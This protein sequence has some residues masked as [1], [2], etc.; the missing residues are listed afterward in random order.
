M[1]TY[2]GWVAGLPW[3]N[4][5]DT[6]RETLS[7][8]DLNRI[9]ALQG[10]NS[11]VNLTLTVYKLD[12]TYMGMQDVSTQLLLCKGDDRKLVAFK[13]FGAQKS[14][15]CSIDLKKLA[16]EYSEPVFYELWIN[17]PSN[18]DGTARAAGTALY[19]VPVI[20]G[21]YGSG[22]DFPNKILGEDRALE[23]GVG[24]AGVEALNKVKLSRRFFLWDNIS[25]RKVLDAQSRAKADATSAPA[26]VSANG[27]KGVS[28]PSVVRWA[29]YME[30]RIKLRTDDSATPYDESVR[31]FPP[32]LYVQYSQQRVSAIP[33]VPPKV[34]DANEAL[35]YPE[36]EFRSTYTMDI[37]HFWYVAMILFIVLVVLI[38]ISFGVKVS[39]RNQSTSLSPPTGMIADL[40]GSVSD[41][42]FWFIFCL[43]GYWFFFFKL[44]SEVK[45]L[46]PL[47]NP[48]HDY[49][50]IVIA[51]IVCKIL[52]VLV[53]VYRQCNVDIFFID[54]EKERSTDEKPSGSG[55]DKDRA[56]NS[57]VSVWRTILIANEW[58]E[59][60]SSRHTDIDLTLMFLLLFLA[61]LDYQYLSTPQPSTGDLAPSDTNAALRF[62]VIAM[63]YFVVVLMQLVWKFVSYRFLNDPLDLFVNLCQLAN[64]SAFVM[65][66][67]YHGYYVHGRAVHP[68]SDVNMYTM[69][70]N[71]QAESDGNLPWRGLTQSSRE[72]L[73]GASNDVFEM[74]IPDT[75]REE[76]DTLFSKTQQN[77]GSGR[78]SGGGSKGNAEVVAKAYH[79][80]N[81]YLQT[82]VVDEVVTRYSSE[83]K[84]PSLVHKLIGMPPKK[85]KEHPVLIRDSSQLF[86]RVLFYGIEYDLVIFDLLIFIMWDLIFHD[87]FIAA[88]LTYVV[89]HALME[90]R[91]TWGGSNIAKKT[92]VDERFLV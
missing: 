52:Q 91:T 8:T 41:F 42:F 1:H 71:I 73:N 30:L 36:V 58:T 45:A 54:W 13:S 23:L 74:Y 56:L 59:M 2:K 64:I 14:V 89:A 61:G 80:I 27:A 92:L 15:T 10:D 67:Q 32:Y 34:G 87:V 12:G 53:L 19:P 79:N 5:E 48:H 57:N 83:V 33:S 86:S 77:A 43:T 3:L 62:F 50:A 70:A 60:Q 9:V 28:S 21:N 44:Q 66:E 68:H 18:P 38:V 46:L 11:L 16:M 22:T 78:G 63:W 55:N 7:Y 72:D 24:G 69:Q 4:Y 84:P 40:L 88:L 26:G 39:V 31:M 25:G 82:S 29:Q 20:I 6:P 17:D 76:Y 81:A 37:G 35:R 75:I 65:D 85:F 47:E 90:L 49:I 51:C